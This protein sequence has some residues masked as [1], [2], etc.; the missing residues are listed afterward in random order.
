[1]KIKSQIKTPPKKLLKNQIETMK[2]SAG[3]KEK[4]VYIGNVYNKF[5]SR[6]PVVRFL[7]RNFYD[8]LSSLIDSVVP[9]RIH[10]IGCGEGYWVIQW[11]KLGFQAKGSDFSKKVI[12]I[13]KIN[14]K[15]NKL[16]D[17]IFYVRNIYD[18]KPELD[19]SELIVCCEVLEHLENPNMALLSLQAVVENYI[20]L[21]VP[22]EPIWRMLNIVR[23]K[24]LGSFGNTPGHIQH[25][26]CKSFVN[27]VSRYFDVED[28][29]KPLPWTMLL[30]KVRP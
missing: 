20:I 23:G 29:R 9:D 1:M 17:E 11:N 25:W 2:I 15:S 7:M 27:L 10:E 26:S 24:Y 3:L 6:N 18:L 30:C 14:A 13:A 19:N 16:S 4:G 28:V 21:S 5:D 22:R 8:N 12:E